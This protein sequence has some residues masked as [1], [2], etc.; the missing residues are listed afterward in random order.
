MKR[1]VLI[2]PILL[3][4]V[5]VAYGQHHHTAD[6]PRAGENYA[7]HSLYHLD[8]EWTD[9]RGNYVI[10]SDFRGAPVI[11][12]MFYGNCTE[13]CPI[14]IRDAWRLYS[15]VDESVRSAVSVLAVTFDTENDTPEVLHQYAE[16]EQLNIPGWHFMTA[17]SSDVRTLATLLGVQY[18]K[19]SD[20]HF[21]HSNLVTVLDEEGR[22]VERIEGLNQPVSDA[23]S[24]INLM[25][26]RDQDQ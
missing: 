7:E 15:A 5:T 18:S 9:H 20:G 19:K 4:A 17:A 12:V 21:S 1:L 16:H 22:I 25:L 6:T 13:V 10:L 2:L 26:D 11:V 3:L 23:A 8:V 14:L 24:T